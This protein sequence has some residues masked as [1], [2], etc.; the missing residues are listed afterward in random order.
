MGVLDNLPSAPVMP[1]NG[2]GAGVVLPSVNVPAP[3]APTS[4]PPI[5]SPKVEQGG[6]FWKKLLGSVLG[7]AINGLGNTGGSS[8]WNIAKAGI[9]AGAG[10]AAGAGVGAVLG[11]VVPGIGTVVGGLVGS[12][13][14]GLLNKVDAGVEN[15]DLSCVG[16]LDNPVKA[17][18]EA[19]QEAHDLLNM[20]G[21]IND[22]LTPEVAT[23]CIT[24]LL[25]VASE[26]RTGDFGHC[27]MRARRVRAEVLERVSSAVQQMAGTS[28]R[29]ISYR[30]VHEGDFIAT[31][32]GRHI[33]AKHSFNVPVYDYKGIS[34]IYEGVDAGGDY[35]PGDRVPLGGYPY[36]NRDEFPFFTLLTLGGIAYLI[37]R[38]K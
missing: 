36:N 11:S 34:G 23:R 4:Y 15:G 16:S 12:L 38:K 33:I 29:L 1:V 21:F 7:G 24:Y 27:T 14:G 17:R 35:R 31:Y 6:S 13:L 5:V 2:V 9:S 32:N 20:A 8:G 10:Y 19:P 18:R 28:L 30:Y 25:G 22:Q 37:F 26:Y 3:S